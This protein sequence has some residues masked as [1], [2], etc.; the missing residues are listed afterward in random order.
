ML[1]SHIDTIINTQLF[2]G[3]NREDLRSMFHCLNPILRNYDKGDYI[4][5]E[6]DD[7]TSIGLILSGEI[8]VS[9]D[10][11]S[12]N[13]NVISQLHKG[14]V[15]GA[16]I[17]FSKSFKSPTDII[18]NDNTIVLM[19]PK[20]RIIGQCSNMCSFH[21]SLIR[22]FLTI[23]SERALSLNKKVELLT[24]KTIKGKIALYLLDQRKIN[25]KDNFTIPLNRNQLAEYLS[26]SR[27]SMSRDLGE[28]KE[29]GMI[30]YHL[31]AFRILDIRAVKALTD[32]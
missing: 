27:P 22:N 15:F 31:N 24:I 18:A 1:N 2:E 16:M 17:A 25:N 4:I 19:L 21:Q 26:I 23:I 28:M 29:D 12:G 30:D 9:R 20:D 32:K 7:L 13:R 11:Y 10:S 3:I 5:H 6:N 14:S 8:I